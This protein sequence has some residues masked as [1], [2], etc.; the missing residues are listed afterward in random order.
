M[1]DREL[2][3]TILLTSQ[4]KKLCSLVKVGPTKKANT[5]QLLF[6]PSLVYIHHTYIC[7]EARSTTGAVV[8]TPKTLPGVMASASGLSP[9]SDPSPSTSQNLVTL[10][11]ATASCRP[12][13]HSVVERISTCTG[14]VI[15]I[16]EVS[17]PSGLS[18]PSGAPSPTGCSLSTSETLSP[19]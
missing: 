17:G 3:W 4:N 18:S 5:D 9:D 8:D 11:Y 6:L 1:P 13:L 7:T 12:M 15:G 2:R 16:I 10:S 14:G 19:P